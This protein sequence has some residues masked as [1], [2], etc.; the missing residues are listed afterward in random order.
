MTRFSVHVSLCSVDSKHHCSFC[1][2]RGALRHS[3]HVL[4]HR[5]NKGKDIYKD[6]STGLPLHG[7]RPRRFSSSPF[8]APLRTVCATGACKC[9]LHTSCATHLRDL[10]SYRPSRPPCPRS[11]YSAPTCIMSVLGLIIATCPGPLVAS[12]RPCCPSHFAFPA[13]LGGVAPQIC[14]SQ[15][16][17]PHNALQR[18]P[19][20]LFSHHFPPHR[21]PRSSCRSPPRRAGAAFLGD[22]PPGR[23][24][25]PH[26]CV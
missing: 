1:A 4:L 18:P 9:L 3:R 13:H 20:F 10:C 6:A 19:V 24:Q 25:G 7:V 21:P 8:Q 17:M 16:A 2:R 11:L 5:R 22:A 26:R 12:A 23:V 14:A 15:S